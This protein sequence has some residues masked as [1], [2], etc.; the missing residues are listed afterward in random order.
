MCDLRTTTTALYDSRHAFITPNRFPLRWGHLLVVSRRHVE[1][2]TELTDEEH[3]EC[4]ALSL[5]AARAVERGFVP[6][7]VFVASLGSARDNLPMTCPHLHWHVV[8]V[9]HGERPRDVLTW[10]HG[11]LQ[12]SEDEWRALE[13]RVRAELTG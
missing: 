5:R 1:R 11:V 8:P 10:R 6:P 13:T 12:A 4:A 2:F 3:A 9:A 7:R